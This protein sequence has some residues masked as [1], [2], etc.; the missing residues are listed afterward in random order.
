MFAVYDL[1]PMPIIRALTILF[2][3]TAATQGYAQF[4]VTEK[5]AIKNIEKQNWTK[6]RALIL[7]SLAKDSTNA[8]AR[9]LYVQWFFNALNPAFDVDSASYHLL[10]ATTNFFQLEPRERTRLAKVPVDSLILTHMRQRVDSAAFEKARRINTEG[11]YQQFLAKFPDTRFEAEAKHLRDEAAYNDAVRLNTYQ[12]FLSF[13]DKYP[14]AFRAAEARD[15]YERLF[16]ESKTRERTLEAY[17]S[18]LSEHPATPYRREVEEHIFNILTAAGGCENFETFLR[19]YPRSLFAKLARDL[20]FHIVEEA[21]HANHNGAMINDSLATLSA[22]NRKPLIPFLKDGSFGFMDTKGTTIL[23]NQYSTIP[24]EYLCGNITED[25]LILNGQLVNRSGHIIASDTIQEVDDLGFGFLKVMSKCLFVIHKSSFRFPGCFENAKII[26]SRFVAVKRNNRWSLHTF[27]GTALS[28]GWDDIKEVNGLIVFEKEKQF[29]PATSDQ[30]ARSIEKS[31]DIPSEGFLEIRPWSRNLVFV[32]N[33]DGQG[34]LDTNLRM[35]VPVSQRTLEKTFFGILLKRA[36]DVEILNT[37]G[38]AIGSAPRV[39]V[40][41]PWVT[42]AY[43][44]TE[45]F[46]DLYARTLKPQKYDS[47]AFVGMVAVGHRRDSATVYFDAANKL[48]VPSNASLSF[49]SGRDSTGYLVVSEKKQSTVFSPAG[50][51]LFTGEYETIKYAGEGL[52]IVGRKDKKGLVTIAGESLLPL[53]YDAVGSV[54][55]G[56]ITFLKSMKFGAYHL[57]KQKL[58]KP[59]FDKNVV[60]Y[61]DDV[62]A[63]FKGGAYYFMG[64]DGKT[65]SKSGF[66]EILYWSDSIALVRN[67]KS[68]SLYDIHSRSMQLQNVERVEY[69]K[70]ADNDKTAIFKLGDVYGVWNNQEGVII[71]PEFSA[72]INVGTEDEPMYFTEKHV[73]IASL[74][75]VIY[76]DRNGRLV[77]REVYEEDDYERILCAD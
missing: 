49:L 67:E 71:S 44:S 38:Q 73:E 46:F 32:S 47:I 22:L 14:H 58:I 62:L 57:A 15:R 51:R 39:N 68:W 1:P 63:A 48:T 2:I 61:T 8:A 45:Q 21:D 18:F 41:K 3:L 29:F 65:I 30:V 50:K 72:L 12:S 33:R 54:N 36:N 60:R 59:Q 70:D 7:K 69:V 42:F 53:D 56:I 74:Y 19:R 27:T 24:D 17:E 28:D 52:F 13:L 23:P 26:A 35:V 16:F 6:A 31:L 76:Y 66:D 10:G 9:Y 55:K 64:W 11:G 40:S 25:I 37:A 77:R 5:S 4:G 34:I 20:L 75:V 43:D